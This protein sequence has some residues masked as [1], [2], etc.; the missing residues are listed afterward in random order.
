MKL[1]FSFLNVSL[2]RNPNV[3]I[4]D[5]KRQILFIGRSQE[6]ARNRILQVQ[7]TREAC[8]ER[9]PDR[10]QPEEDARSLKRSYNADISKSEI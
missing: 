1:R 8:A 7:E 5:Y 9:K 3:W 2:R 10:A 4:P 6:L